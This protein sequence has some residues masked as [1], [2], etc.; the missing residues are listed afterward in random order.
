MSATI[1]DFP[2]TSPSPD[3]LAPLR[4]GHDPFL[5]RDQCR[6]AEALRRDYRATRMTEARLLAFWDAVG[7]DQAFFHPAAAE[8]EAEAA[9]VRLAQ[10]LALPGNDL[11]E[12]LIRVVLLNQSLGTYEKFAALPARSGKVL[13][14][15]AL[16]R[17]VSRQITPPPPPPPDPP[18]YATLE[19]HIAGLPSDA[20]R[21]EYCLDLL[22]GFLGD[23][24]TSPDRWRKIGLALS[25]TEAAILTL[26]ARRP[27]RTVRRSEIFTV[28]YGA[29]P[30]ADAIP[31]DRAVDSAIYRLRVKIATADLPVVIEKRP[32]VGYTLTHPEDFQF[33]PEKEA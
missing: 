8:T 3:A 23:D 16:E 10:A 9:C 27:G 20:E 22:R 33:P 2:E 21:V 5:T 7:R 26:L 30:D 11:A 19:T 6:A 17:L 14:R 28:L 29:R 31:S 32:S 18:A 12:A 1:H 4:M 15:I 13:V 24:P 25:P